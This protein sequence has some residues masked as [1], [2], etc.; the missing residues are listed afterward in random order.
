MAIGVP[1]SLNSILMSSSNIVINNMMSRFNDMAVAGLGVAMKV[2][3]IVVM[4]LIGLGTGIQPASW[5]L[6]WSR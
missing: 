4:L 3:M 2:N 6:F 5:I 1:A